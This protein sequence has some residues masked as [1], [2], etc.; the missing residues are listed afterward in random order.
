MIDHGQ[1]GLTLRM[2]TR[3]RT[4][5]L[6]AHGSYMHTYVYTCMFVYIVHISATQARF[7]V[8]VARPMLLRAIIACAQVHG[9]LH[10]PPTAPLQWWLGGAFSARNKEDE[11]T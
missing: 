6:H 2:H 1:Y 4:I 5:I 9:D 3:I 7:A 10:W 11:G 8:V